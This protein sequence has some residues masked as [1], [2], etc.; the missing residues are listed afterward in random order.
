MNPTPTDILPY[1][2]AKAY[3]KKFDGDIEETTLAV[4]TA[5]Q[6]ATR[7]FDALFERHRAKLRHLTR[8]AMGAVRSMFV[9]DGE[10]LRWPGS[11]AM[12]LVKS[13]TI[14]TILARAKAYAEEAVPELVR[15][16]PNVLC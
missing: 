13:V 9:A 10:S 7:T 16:K 3:V 1:R 2:G 4:E 11:D 14:S 12:E 6:N 8:Q 15:W 5:P